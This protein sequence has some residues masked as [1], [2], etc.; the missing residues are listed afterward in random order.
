MESER[1]NQSDAHHK[2]KSHTN[3]QAANHTEWLTDAITATDVT[4]NSESWST[5]MKAMTSSAANAVLTLSKRW[6][7]SERTQFRIKKFN[8]L[9]NLSR[10]QE[11]QFRGLWIF[12][13]SQDRR[14]L[15]FNN[16]SRDE[17]S[18]HSVLE[19]TV[20]QMATLSQSLFLMELAWM[21][22]KYKH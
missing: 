7:L 8:K 19:E 11:H 18:L 6:N 17:Q 10:L 16:S 22:L 3:K 4:N 9:S 1:N 5:W 15:Q 14:L 2:W 20:N 13:F 12:Q 21:S